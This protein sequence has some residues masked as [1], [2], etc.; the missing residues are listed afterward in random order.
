MKSNLETTL[1]EPTEADVREYAYHLYIRSG[2]LPGRDLENWLEAKACL[3]IGPALA[4]TVSPPRHPARTHSRKP[5][6]SFSS[7]EAKNLAV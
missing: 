4:E 5:R 2:C 6:F 1:E 3:G 7:P